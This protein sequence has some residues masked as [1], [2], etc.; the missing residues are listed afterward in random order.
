MV[1]RVVFVFMLLVCMQSAA[2]HALP[3][4]TDTIPT[5]LF[6]RGIR[7]VNK[8][9]PWHHLQCVYITGTEVYN[10]GREGQSTRHWWRMSYIGRAC[11]A[12]YG[13]TFGQIF[14][15]FFAIPHYI[16]IGIGNGIGYMVYLVRG[17]PEKIQAR[18]LKRAQRR[19]LRKAEQKPVQPDSSG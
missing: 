15:G 16:G 17:S 9:T 12:Q 7:N 1:V 5:P 13:T 8:C 19:L 6:E 11:T 10:D 14:E 18:K 3:I 2:Q 4:V